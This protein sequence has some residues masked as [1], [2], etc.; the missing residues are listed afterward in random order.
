MQYLVYLQKEPF[1]PWK[2]NCKQKVILFEFETF[3]K[4]FAFWEETTQFELFFMV[5]SP[6]FIQWETGEVYNIFY[7]QFKFRKMNI[8]KRRERKVFILWIFDRYIYFY[9]HQHNKTFF[10][11][12]KFKILIKKAL[13][14]REIGLYLKLFFLH[15]DAY[16]S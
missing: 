14:E 5:F 11:S 4:W 15:W 7:H 16:P 1:F 10:V 3:K 8:S 9:I 12:S 13:R 2:Q 6:L